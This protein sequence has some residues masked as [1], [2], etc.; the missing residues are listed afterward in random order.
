MSDLLAAARLLGRSP[1][2]VVLW[3]IQPASLDVGLELSSTVADQ[4][5]VLLQNV[6]AELQRWGICPLNDTGS[7]Q[8]HQE[9]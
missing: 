1:A 4:V 3:G 5:E 2:E 6:L 7:D 9:G 8:L